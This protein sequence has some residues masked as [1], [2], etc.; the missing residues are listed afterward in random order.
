MERG[1]TSVSFRPEAT[2][3]VVARLPRAQPRQDAGPSRSSSTS[4]RCSAS[5]GRR[6]GSQRQ[7]YQ[8]GIEALGSMSPLLDAEVMLVAHA[9]LR[10]AGRPATSRSTST[11]S[12]TR[13]TATAS[14]TVLVE[15]MRHAPRT[16][17][18]TTASRALRAQRVPHARLQGPGLPAEQ[19]ERSA[20]PRPPAAPESQSTFRR[21]AS[22]RCEQSRASRSRSTTVSSAGWTTTRTPCSR[23]GVPTSG[24]A[25]RSA[26]A[27]ATTA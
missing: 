25:T 11:A 8:I 26:A 9:L 27:V 7:F 20:H 19:P 24:R 5:S 21:G 12:A 18:A 4:A 17:A 14:A 3:A 13:R 1:D 16:S 10:R 6:P 23:C 2:A 15:H 22:P